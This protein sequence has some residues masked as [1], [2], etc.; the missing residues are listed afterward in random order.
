[1]KTIHLFFAMSI[2]T[3]LSLTACAAH[4]NEHRAHHADTKP[5]ETPKNETAK[6]DSTPE[7]PTA[8]ELMA[9]ESIK[10]MDT[11]IQSMHDMHAKM[12]NSKTPNE[13]KA[14][15]QEHMKV[16]QSG[17]AMINSDPEKCSTCKMQ[18]MDN[19]K[20]ESDAKEKKMLCTY[21]PSMAVQHQMLEK[22]IQMIEAMQQMMMD[23]LNYNAAPYRPK[24]DQKKIIKNSN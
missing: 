5:M 3:L 6:N 19:M 17:M 22:R 15:M 20:K 12:M 24:S 1:M 4:K 8:Q 21:N 16:M 11:Q 7:E 13:R 18:G 14:H 10:K 9:M 2:F 23:R